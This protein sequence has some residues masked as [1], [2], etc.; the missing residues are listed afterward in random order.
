MAE[1]NTPYE[2]Q[3]VNTLGKY[4]ESISRYAVCAT[5]TAIVSVYAPG[6]F[7]SLI[8]ADSRCESVLDALTA[9]RSSLSS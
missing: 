9:Q 5:L 3:L 6:L 1:I 2:I 4:A 7:S 8:A